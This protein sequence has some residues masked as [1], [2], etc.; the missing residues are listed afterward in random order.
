MK[1]TRS[2]ALCPHVSATSGFSAC[3]TAVLLLFQCATHSNA[4]VIFSQTGA[5]SVNGTI[6]SSTYFAQSFVNG[7]TVMSF[8]SVELG[9]GPFLTDNSGNFF[10]SLY[11]N[12][13][14]NL[15]GTLV[16][17]LSGSTSPDTQNFYT[18]TGSGSTQ[19]LADTGY[20]IV[21]G[22]SSGTGQY[23]W[24]A[25]SNNS[26]EVGSTVYQDVAKSSNAG[27]SWVYNNPGNSISLQM[28][29]NAA[30]VPEPSRALLLGLGL[31]VTCLRRKRKLAY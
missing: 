5:P 6:N 26:P 20:W 15:P 14:S 31:V 22:V 13:G 3:L 21:A 30:A 29:V 4:T 19:L 27:G 25:E 10:V 11:T 17:T 18:Y 1:T 8:T 7:S 23:R 9:M 2:K 12:S 28:I 16:E 24:N